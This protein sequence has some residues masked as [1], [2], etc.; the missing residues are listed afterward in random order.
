M[1]LRLVD[2]DHPALHKPT[3]PCEE[4]PSRRIIEQM[5]WV[6]RHSD[7]FALAA[8]QVGLSL[9]LF[10]LR[11]GQVVMNPTVD[12]K[13]ELEIEFIERCLSL[14]GKQFR[15][16]RP[17]WI[18]ASWDAMDGERKGDRIDGWDARVWLHEIDHLEG[19]LISERWPEVVPEA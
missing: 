11:S 13:S 3:E 12:A 15:V 17:G 1:K 6:C 9:Q 19:R 10:V 4:P 16:R 2:A 5:L 8:P 7:G 14:P 18:V